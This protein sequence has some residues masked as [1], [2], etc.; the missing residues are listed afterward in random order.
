MNC[1][2]N[3]FTILFPDV[4]MLEINLSDNAFSKFLNASDA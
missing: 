4:M 2:K 3:T 1:W